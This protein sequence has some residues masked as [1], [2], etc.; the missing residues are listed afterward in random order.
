MLIIF[1]CKRRQFINSMI[2]ISTLTFFVIAFY[3]LSCADLISRPIRK[4]DMSTFEI[5]SFYDPHTYKDIQTSILRSAELNPPTIFLPISQS[6]K[7]R[8]FIYEVEYF[9]S[10]FDMHIDYFFVKVILLFKW[11]EVIYGMENEIFAQYLNVITPSS[12]HAISEV[13][14]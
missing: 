11:R 12:K 10:D 4:I 9:R 2:S 13:H 1:N 5:S 6:I 3:P 14:C 7:Y 8:K